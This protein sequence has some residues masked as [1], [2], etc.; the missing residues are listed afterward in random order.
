M[1]EFGTNDAYC[2]DLNGWGDALMR[3]T[4]LVTLFVALPSCASIQQQNVVAT[5]VGQSLTAGVGDVVLRVEGRE[6][7]P[8]AFGHADLFGRTRPTS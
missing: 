2:Y 4:I 8:N 7:M 3:A 5:T 6:S 1:M